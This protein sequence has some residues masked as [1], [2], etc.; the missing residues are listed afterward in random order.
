MLGKPLY[1]MTGKE[2]EARAKAGKNPEALLA[3]ATMI[4]QGWRGLDSDEDRALELE[5]LAASMGH[6][7]ALS[8][9]GDRYARGNVVEVDGAQAIMWWRRAAEAGD[10]GA[11]S[12]LIDLRESDNPRE[13]AEGEHWLKLAASRGQQYA[14]NIVNGGTPSTLS[15]FAKMSLEDMAAAA[16]APSGQELSWEREVRA[17]IAQVNDLVGVFVERMRTHFFDVHTQSTIDHDEADFPQPDLA[18]IESL[19]AEENTIEAMIYAGPLHLQITL[20]PDDGTWSVSF[21]SY[22]PH[23]STHEK[24]WL[25]AQL[26]ETMRQL[27]LH[28]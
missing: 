13:R 4:A 28:V 27:G 19:V 15:D 6:P 25:V 12:N 17:S 10:V 1:K 20:S 2:L 7:R 23:P 21:S 26:V 18:E 24:Q 5:K 14:L 16:P 9:L 11:M 22:E 8:R 3:L